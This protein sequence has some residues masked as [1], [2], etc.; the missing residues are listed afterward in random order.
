MSSYSLLI[1]PYHLIVNVNSYI[2]IRVTIHSYMYI[3]SKFQVA[4]NYIE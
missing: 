2:K 1:I 4:Y 3:I